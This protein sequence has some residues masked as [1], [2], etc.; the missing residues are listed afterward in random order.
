MKQHREMPEELAK[1]YM[2]QVTDGLDYLHFNDIIHRDV[3][4]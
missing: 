2:S 4:P 3:K 1:D